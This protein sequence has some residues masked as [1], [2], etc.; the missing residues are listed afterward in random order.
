MFFNV[1]SHWETITEDG[2][3]HSCFNKWGIIS[4][5][6]ASK[7]AFTSTDGLWPSSD[8]HDSAV[9]AVRMYLHLPELRYRLIA[10]MFALHKLRTTNDL[11][12]HPVE[13]YTGG[14]ALSTSSFVRLFYAITDRLVC[15]FEFTGSYAFAYTIPCLYLML[16]IPLALDWWHE[17]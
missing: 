13:S 11:H 5:L 17:Q 8:K 6:S 4:I 12:R 7:A 14:K 10:V 1:L 9:S 16:K 15:V 2:C 3:V